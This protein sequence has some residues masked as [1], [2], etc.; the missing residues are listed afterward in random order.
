[1][2][3]VAVFLIAVYQR[4]ISPAFPPSCRFVPTCSHYAK[5]AIL[6]YGFL[7]GGRIWASGDCSGV[8]RFTRADTTLFPEKKELWNEKTLIAV[9]IS[10]VTIV[11]GVPLFHGQSALFLSKAPCAAQPNGIASI[12]SAGCY[13]ESGA[14][15]NWGWIGGN[16]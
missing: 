8:T 1:V 13:T 7:G 15:G 16:I 6:N 14:Y 9:V 2:R 5:E 12:V 3:F 11:E 10:A 4:I